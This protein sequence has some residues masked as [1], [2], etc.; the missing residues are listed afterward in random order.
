[1]S[2]FRFALAVLFLAASCMFAQVTGRLTGTV[3][4]P[5]GA[6]VPNAKVGIYLPGGKTPL[7]ST[8]TNS[9]G[10]FDFLGVR[11]DLYLLQIDAAGFTRHTQAEIKIDPER[12][13][14][15][16]PIKLS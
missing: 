14:R 10:I 6:S 13:L 16:P 12:E 4:D 15:L 1:M 3:V 7:L 8:T 9:D 2:N 5:S 11:P